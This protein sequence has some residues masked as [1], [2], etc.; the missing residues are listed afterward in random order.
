MRLL[1][2]LVVVL[3]PVVIVAAEAPRVFV[4]IQ[5]VIPTVQSGQPPTFEIVVA[6]DTTDT[7]WLPNRAAL[8]FDFSATKDG[9]AIPV[10]HENHWPPLDIDFVE[11]GPR[12]S[13]TFIGKAFNLASLPP[14]H[15]LVKATYR[16]RRSGDEPYSSES[17]EV[18][19]HVECCRT[20]KR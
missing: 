13:V 18:A 1:S 5:P 2:I 19:L 20:A 14:G 4:S 12:G 17:N 10:E 3:A 11:V 6:N 7:L 9:L 15:Y 16:H 8:H